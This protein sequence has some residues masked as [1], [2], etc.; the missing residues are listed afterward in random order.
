M[1]VWCVKIIWTATI[2]RDKISPREWNNLNITNHPIFPD[3]RRILEVINVIFVSDD[4]HK[5]HF[6]KVKNFFKKL[7]GQLGKVTITIYWQNWQYQAVLRKE[8]FYKSMKDTCSFKNTYL[9]DAHKK[10]EIA[11]VIQKFF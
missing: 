5:K 8:A 7:K 3:V 1:T 2:L 9:D 4:R 10:I 6:M 11:A